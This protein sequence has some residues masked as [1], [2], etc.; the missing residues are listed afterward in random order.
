[1][2]RKT[3]T[4]LALTGALALGTASA[5]S[6]GSFDDVAFAGGSVGL[7]DCA[8]AGD[9]LSLLPAIPS[10]GDLASSLPTVDPLALPDA[11]LLL[12]GIDLSALPIECLGKVAD[13][14]LIGEDLVAGTSEVLAVL[15]GV[16]LSAADTVPIDVSAA[17]LDTSLVTE[18]RIVV[19]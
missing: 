8:L 4:A 1:M 15:E 17:G 5:T 3:T 10:V 12:A 9:A 14:V 7:I 19:R 11:S 18:V 13:I 6:L 2:I 16:D